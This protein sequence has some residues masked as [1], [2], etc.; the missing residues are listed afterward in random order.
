MRL[1]GWLLTLGVVSAGP[2]LRAQIAPIAPPSI[3]KEDCGTLKGR[4]KAQCEK[5]NAAGENTVAK[6]ADASHDTPTGA[7]ADVPGE[8]PTPRSSQNGAAK[9]KPDT[10]DMPKGTDADPPSSSMG[11]LRPDGTPDTE[12]PPR[13]PG[14]AS[15]SSSSDDDDVA[16]TT[17]ASDTPVKAATLKDLGSHAESSEARVKL[18][19]NRVYD[20]VKVGRFYLR[21][22]NLSGAE[23][24]FRD[25]L[26]HDPDDPE[27]H[28]AMAELLLKQKRSGE[29]AAQLKRYLELAPEDDHTK[30]AKKMLTKLGK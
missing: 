5:R 16:P 28:F 13:T 27:A 25:A 19:Q 26:Q 6:P 21:D 17:S 20:D 24:R 2:A 7:D 23:A 29:A 10:S 14:A 22:G 1:A 11:P 9:A 15:S 4:A 3:L 18:E 12:G 30:D 8:P